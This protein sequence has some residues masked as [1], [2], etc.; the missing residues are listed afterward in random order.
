MAADSS[1]RPRDERIHPDDGGPAGDA[2]S[3]NNDA[4]ETLAEKIRRYSQA[5]PSASGGASAP[6]GKVVRQRRED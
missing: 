4:D 3:H 5:G 6:A 1:R 2:R